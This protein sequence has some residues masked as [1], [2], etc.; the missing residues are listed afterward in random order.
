[1]LMA[2]LTFGRLTVAGV[3][4]IAMVLA[5]GSPAHAHGFRV[6]EGSDYAGVGDDH[7]WTEVCDLER[8]GNGVYAT[9]T[10]WRGDTHTVGDS[11]GANGGCGNWT[12][13]WDVASIV[14]C[15]DDWGGDTCSGRVH[16]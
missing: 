13:P 7:R 9:Y 12:A 10:S 4:M 3:A 15:E 16:P 8:D 1:M 14:V 11:N 6:Y 2:R 5:T